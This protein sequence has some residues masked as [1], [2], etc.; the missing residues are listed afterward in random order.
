MQESGNNNIVEEYTQGLNLGHTC[1]SL[2]MVCIC[3][4]KPDCG[5]AVHNYALESSG[6]P[7]YDHRQHNANQASEEINLRTL[8]HTIAIACYSLP[9]Y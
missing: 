7:Q 3:K 2:F 9:S 6:K 5:S 1:Y 4:S 8:I